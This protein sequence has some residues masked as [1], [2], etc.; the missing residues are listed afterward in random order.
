MS[1]ERLKQAKALEMQSSA[2]VVGTIDN[3]VD[4]NTENITSTKPDHQL[5]GSLLGW[6]SVLSSTSIKEGELYHF[7]MYVSMLFKCIQFEWT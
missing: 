6:Y 7:S 2:A 1:E 4:G 3:I 5:S